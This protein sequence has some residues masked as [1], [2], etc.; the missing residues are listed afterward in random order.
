VEEGQVDAD[1]EGDEAEDQQCDA[2][3]VEPSGGF[4]LEGEA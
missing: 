4:P 1:G 3:E 2:A